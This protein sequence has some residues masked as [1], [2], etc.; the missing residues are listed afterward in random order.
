[1]FDSDF[2]RV[3]QLYYGSPN[4][5]IWGFALRLINYC[6]IICI[7]NL[8]NTFPDIREEKNFM[9]VFAIYVLMPYK[10][11]SRFLTYMKA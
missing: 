3:H 7:C 4:K 9:L 1:M 5:I 6:K 8:A 11:S 10:F 2:L